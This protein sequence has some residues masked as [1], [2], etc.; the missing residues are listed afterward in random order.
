[1]KKEQSE[2]IHSG[3]L[4]TGTVTKVKKIWW[5]KIKTQVINY[6]GTGKYMHKVFYDFEVNGKG[7]TGQTIISYT[8]EPPKVGQAVPVYYMADDPQKN[9]LGI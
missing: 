1:M 2:I 6:P 4:T 5:V 3:V 9:T 7:Y 8:I